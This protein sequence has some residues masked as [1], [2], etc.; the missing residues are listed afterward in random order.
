MVY[1]YQHSGELLPVFSLLRSALA[2]DP[3]IMGVRDP[4]LRPE[5]IV[6]IFEDC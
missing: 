1:A 2:G 5:A 6:S 4:F 3:A